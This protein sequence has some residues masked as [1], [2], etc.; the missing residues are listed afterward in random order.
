[1][2][3]ELLHKIPSRA[4]I[5]KIMSQYLTMALGLQRPFTAIGIGMWLALVMAFNVWFIIWPNQKKA[6][7]IVTVEAAEKAQAARL[8]MLTSR[9]N[10]MLSIPMLYCMVA[11]Q[12]AGL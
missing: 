12:N 6:L 10:T 5:V 1:M 8:A 11:Q 7:G 4:T 9:F 3:L 2:S